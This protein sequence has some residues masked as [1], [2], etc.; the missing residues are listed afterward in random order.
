MSCLLETLKARATVVN[1]YVEPGQDIFDS[2]IYV[3]GRT[4]STYRVVLLIVPGAACF[5]IA[6]AKRLGGQDLST[7]QEYILNNS[8]L[9][10]ADTPVVLELPVP[11]DSKVNFRVTNPQTIKFAA[12][13]VQP[14]LFGTPFAAPPQG[15][16]GQGI[17]MHRPIP[18]GLTVTLT[19][20]K[21]TPPGTVLELDVYPMQPNRELIRVTTA[22][23][24]VPTTDQD[25]RLAVSVLAE[26]IDHRI[27][28]PGLRADMP[29]LSSTAST[30]T[31]TI[32]GSKY[33]PEYIRGYRLILRAE[34]RDPAG[35]KSPTPEDYTV[36]M[37]LSGEHIG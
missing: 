3:E 13:F 30:K 19:V 33:G 37:S 12:V 17:I 14:A 35:D 28:E 36:T 1:K 20:P 26:S 27:T 29:V 16:T 7:P 10:L 34:V 9:V 23:A 11:G 31:I 32:D 18:E 22:T 21:G 6:V 25:G 5:V 15:T 8:N 2:D 24:T 4:D